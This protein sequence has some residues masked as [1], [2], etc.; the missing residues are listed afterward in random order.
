MTKAQFFTLSVLATFVS[1][2]LPKEN[3]RLKEQVD[4]LKVELETN[5]NVSNALQEV[6]SMIDSI[7]FNRHLL[8]TKMVEGTSV[9]DF[10]TRMKDI[11]DY[12]KNAERKITSL[13]KSLVD[14]RSS[15]KQYAQQ[16]KKLRADLEDRNKEL[17]ALQEKVNLFQNENSN[18]VQTVN[19]QKAEIEDKLAQIETKTKES[20]KLQQEV[21]QLVVQ[22]KL[23]ESEAYY[24]KGTLL[25]ETARRTKFA[26]RKKKETTLKAIDMYELAALCGND[27][28]AAK[29]AELKKKVL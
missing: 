8:R 20:E 16:L 1:C 17:V 4:S 5:K 18:L 3:A 27:K 7:D 24:V 9:E 28:A 19:L 6:G 13:E 11:N 10:K 25:E 14:T 12:V 29:V 21:Q 26:P 22:S 2:N 15:G 23:D